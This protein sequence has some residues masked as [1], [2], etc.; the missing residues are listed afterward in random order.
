MKISSVRSIRL[1]LVASAITILLAA[2]GGGNSSTESAPTG[3]PATNN[4]EAT[5]SQITAFSVS[6]TSSNRVAA[7]GAVVGKATGENLV[8][9]TGAWPTWAG[10]DSGI[11]YDG[12]SSVLRI[13]GD[14]SDLVLGVNRFETPL[15]EGVSYNFEVDASN[16]DAAA[17]LFLFD[18][19]GA[20]VPVPGSDGLSVSRTGVP[21][22]F[23]APADIA[24]FYLQVQNQYQANEESTLTAGLIEGGP[25]AEP[26]GENLIN[27]ND[28]WL[29]WSGNDV[30]ISGE[31][32]TVS[33]PMPAQGTGNNI[34]VK[35][36]EMALV[37]NTKYELAA[38]DLSDDG[39]AVLLFLFD[40]NSQ[41]IPFAGESMTMTWLAV[42][43]GE[44]QMF[45][46]PAGVVGY[47]I[48]VQ[49]PY[50]ASGVTSITP[51]LTT[52]GSGG[53]GG[54]GDNEA[55]ILSLV[56]TSDDGGF[57]LYDND[58]RQWFDNACAD[59]LVAAQ[60][61]VTT[62]PWTDI[63]ALAQLPGVAVCDDLIATDSDLPMPD[64]QMPE[65]E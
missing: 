61:T 15:V 16:P 53:D 65:L 14:G 2:C 32:G 7:D 22:Q 28:A 17:V 9:L 64:P 56:R 49:S 23:V 8:D 55:G 48:Q 6:L 54:D 51:S 11:V 24:G 45:T 25:S 27:A 20:I 1:A 4:A 42:A 47:A 5:N 13:P 41:L 38:L 29:D 19:A 12:E 57:V 10:E 58:T 46:A 37:A 34:G 40:E 63:Q 3:S 33:I 30:G 26:M 35:R 52:V 44:A 50:Q 36:S 31:N 60:M 21:V 62:V 39:T 18:A 59:A 43:A